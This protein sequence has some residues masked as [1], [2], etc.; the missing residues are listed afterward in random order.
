MRSIQPVLLESDP[1]PPN[2]QIREQVAPLRSGGEAA[3]TIF[4]L[5]FFVLR[6]SFNKNPG[7]FSFF[8]LFLFFLF[9]FSGAP[10]PRGTLNS[11]ILGTTIR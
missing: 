8:F 2:P 6:F 10:T 4:L 9:L 11:Y 5:V 3:A 1:N 7:F